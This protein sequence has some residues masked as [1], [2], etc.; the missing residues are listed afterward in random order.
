MTTEIGRARVGVATYLT[1]SGPL[2]EPHRVLA[3]R[4]AIESCAEARELQVVVDLTGVPQLGSDALE[5]LLDAQEM[6]SRLGGSLRAA[7]PSAL[8]RDVFRLT[9]LADHVALIAQDEGEAAPAE[10][11]HPRRRASNR[12]GELLVERGLVQPEQIEAALA[13]NQQTG[14]RMAQVLVEKGWISERDLLQTLGEQLAVPFVA[15]RAGVYDPACA[16]LLDAET[17]RRLEVLPL[18]R[19]RKQLFLATSDPQSIP[20]FEH[21]EDV[22]GLRVKPVLAC[23][24][25]IRKAIEEAYGGQ[26]DLAGYIGDL[27]SDLELVETHSFEDQ[28]A[29]DELAAGSPVINLINGVIQRAVRDRASDVHIEPSRKRCR[30]RMRVDGVLYT[31]MTPPMDIHP[32]LVSRLKVMANLDIAERRLPQDGRLQVMTQ[33]RAVDLRFSS[34]PGI[35]GEK[36]VLRVL[37]KDQSILDIEKLGLSAEHLA[38]F[39]R[40]L[41]QSY[42]LLLVTGPTGSGKTT[43]LYAAV[44]H[45]ASDEKNIVTIEDPVEY[46]VD[47]INQNQVRDAIGLSFA[48]ILKH[49]LRQDPDIVMVGEIR[50]KET[51][52]IAVQAALTGHL[53]LSTLHTNDSIGAVT[54]MLDMGVEPFLLSSALIGVMA[55]RLVRTVCPKCKT[56]YA[57]PADALAA[58]GVHSQEQLRLA[59][60]RGCPDCFDSGYK[61][62]M[63]IHEIVAVDPD[64]QRLIMTNPSRS[65]LDDYLRAHQVKTLLD[66]GLQRALEGRTTVEEVMRAVNN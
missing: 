46:Q 7:N 3:L 21:V 25:D 64:L 55:Q 53:V 59:K 38:C 30:I 1:P 58:H 42:G 60:G 32:A 8:L 43:T 19:L 62:R 10:T 36:V 23:G 50:E 44:N 40:L 9:G 51:A 4:Q 12:I 29:I 41:A 18:F 13:L 17:A 28:A 6:L 11:P 24:G 56:T 47:Q 61:G 37:D 33:G 34:L 26:H 20:T 65:D 57:A 27:E 35:F 66:N 49:T 22:T 14:A 48:R 39:R 2:L 15:L 5:A 52:E 54:R 63:A 45:L 31:T 16:R